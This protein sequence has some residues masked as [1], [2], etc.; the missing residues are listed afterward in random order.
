MSFYGESADSTQAYSGNRDHL[1]TYHLICT[2]FSVKLITKQRC[3]ALL[4]TCC[5]H[6]AKK[7]IFAV[8]IS[9]FSS[10]VGNRVFY[11]TKD[12]IPTLCEAAGLG[13]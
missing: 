9:C 4:F 6:T 8:L 13:L 3:V 12:Q 10:E 5:F 2:Y 11:F 1:V 7:T